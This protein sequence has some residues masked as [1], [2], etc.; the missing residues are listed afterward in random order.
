MTQI[1]SVILIDN[2]EVDIFIN[3]KLLERYG[4]TNIC[5][6]KNIKDALVFLTETERTYQLILVGLNMPM[7]DGFQFIDKFQELELNKKHGKILLLSAFFSPLDIEN[8]NERNIRFIEKPL[9]IEELF[10]IEKSS[11]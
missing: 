2:N 6:F 4:L 8:A 9:N 3:S 5:V 10:E 1:T 11:A 7:T